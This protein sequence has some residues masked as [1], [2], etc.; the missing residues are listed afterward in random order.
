MGTPYNPA[1]AFAFCH[2]HTAGL[3]Q[4]VIAVLV[5]QDDKEGWWWGQRGVGDVAGDRLVRSSASKAM[6]GWGT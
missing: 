3:S 6:E 2:Y 4:S 1:Q 5:P